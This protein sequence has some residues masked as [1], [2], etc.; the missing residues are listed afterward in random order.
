M[1]DLL[2]TP[3]VLVNFAMCLANDTS[4]TMAETS[5][6]VEALPLYKVIETYYRYTFAK[7]IVARKNEMKSDN[8]VKGV[9]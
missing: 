6:S 2:N 5:R 4:S 1:D 7:K 8:S 3:I 9:L